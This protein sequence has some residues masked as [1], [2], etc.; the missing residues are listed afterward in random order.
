MCVSL[1]SLSH[2]AANA[3]RDV[4]AIT[5]QSARK[6][7]ICTFFDIQQMSQTVGAAVF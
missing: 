7:V 1:R 5:P 3:A 6:R 2:E 4:T